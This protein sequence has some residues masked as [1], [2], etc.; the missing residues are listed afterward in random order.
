MLCLTSDQQ[1]P[2]L[3]ARLQAPLLHRPECQLKAAERVRTGAKQADGAAPLTTDQL[4]HAP[5][6]RIGLRLS[7]ANPDF[8]GLPRGQ[9]SEL[10][11]ASHGLQRSVAR[12]GRQDPAIHCGANHGYVEALLV[13]EGHCIFDF[14]SSIGNWKSSMNCLPQSQL[15]SKMRVPN[16]SNS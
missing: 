13:N 4:V 8:S 11:T 12:Q 14:R 10:R 5:H 16:F 15:Y 7:I 1:R 6:L 3:S 9:R 2:G